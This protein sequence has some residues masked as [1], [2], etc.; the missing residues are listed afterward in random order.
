[1][2]QRQWTGFEVPDF[3]A[4]SASIPHLQYRQQGRRQP[5]P[6]RTL[7]IGN[8][9]ISEIAWFVSVCIPR[10]ERFVPDDLDGLLNLFR[11]SL[12]SEARKSICPG[13]WPYSKGIRVDA[14]TFHSGTGRLPATFPLCKLLA[15]IQAQQNVC[16][17]ISSAFFARNDL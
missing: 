4:R 9:C 11:I 6:D 5:Q 12:S 8:H 1:M 14:L 16:R 10:E 7:S 2:Q 13:V 15:A 3:L 17:V